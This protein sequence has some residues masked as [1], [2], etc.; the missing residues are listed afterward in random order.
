M[1]KLYGQG[2]T[3]KQISRALLD[4]LAGG[5]WQDRPEEQR[6]R[7]ARNTLTRLERRQDFRDLVW[8]QAVVDLDMSTP[9]ILA[10]VK[11]KAKRGRVDAARL[12][13]EVTGRHNPKGDGAPPQVV[14]AINGVPRP[15]DHHIV[16]LSRPR[17]IE[18]VVAQAVEAEED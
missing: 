9:Q 16:P 18:A 11:N 6:L 17:E 10:G 12:A 1:A 5:D 2:F 13:L 14:V 7:K 3:R 8:D 4:Y 15:A